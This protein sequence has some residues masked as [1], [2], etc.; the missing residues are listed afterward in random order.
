MKNLFVASCCLLLFSNFQF[1]TTVENCDLTI[2]FD[3]IKSN[4]GNIKLGLANSAIGFKKM[5]FY[6][7]AIVPISNKKARYTFK[8]LPYG[9]YAFSAFHDK[10]NNG[11][12]DTNFLGIPTDPYAFSNNARGRF[13]PPSFEKAKF[14]LNSSTKSMHVIL[15]GLSL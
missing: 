13:G 7:A 4:K 8:N 6:R 9:T 3:N 2:I 1:T 5:K 12:L 15:N 14:E 10:N 11:K